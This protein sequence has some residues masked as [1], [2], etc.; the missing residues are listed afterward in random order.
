MR[1]YC[2]TWVD[3]DQGFS[4]VWCANKHKA[5]RER[6]EIARNRAEFIESINDIEIECVEFPSR[7]RDL[8]AWLNTHATGL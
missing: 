7:K 8:I 2:C 5:E 4:R 3:A 1:V 6:R